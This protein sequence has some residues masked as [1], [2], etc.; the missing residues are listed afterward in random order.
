MIHRIDRVNPDVDDR[1][2]KPNEARLATNLRFGAS[3]DDE[4]LSGGTLFLGN[5]QLPFVAP[6]GTNVCVGIYAEYENRFVFFAM[7]NNNGNHGIYRINSFDNSVQA[8][9]AGSWL[10]FQQGDTYNV[11][12]TSIDGKLYWTDNVNEPRMVNVEKGIRTEAGQTVD[13]YPQA[14]VLDWFY[15]QIK[16]PPGMPLSVAPML[17]EDLP[18][19]SMTKQNRALTDTGFQYSYYYVY[20]N[21]EES[22]LAPYSKNT[23]GNYNIVVTIPADEFNTYATYTSLIK[24]IVIVIRNGNDGVWREIRYIPNDGVTRTFAFTNIL[25]SQK[26]IVSS[27]ITDARFD[28]VPLESATNEIAQNKINHGNYRLDYEPVEGITFNAE[29]VYTNDTNLWFKS[30]Y[31][32]KYKSFVPWG[33]YSIGVEFVDKFGRTQPVSNVSEVVAPWWVAYFKTGNDINAGSIDLSD[34]NSFTNVT[35][36]EIYNDITRSVAKFSISGDIP[37]WVDRV[38]IVR[39]KCKNIV[40]MKQSLGTMYMWYKNQDGQDEFFT[41]VNYGINPYIKNSPQN[42]WP[43]YEVYNGGNPDVKYTFQGYIIEFNAGEPIVQAENQYIYLPTRYSAPTI[44]PDAPQNNVIYQTWSRFKVHNVVGN[45]IYILASDGVTTHPYTA[46]WN[47][48]DTTIITPYTL[49]V[50]CFNTSEVNGFPMMGDINNYIQLVYNFVITQEVE[51]D[52]Q[53]LYTTQKSYSADE[54]RQAINNNNTLTGY[55]SGDAYTC[56]ALKTTR[57]FR[58][59]IKIFNPG[60]VGGQPIINNV[61]QRINSLGWYGFFISMNPIDIYKE[62]WNQDIGQVNTTNYKDTESRVLTNAIC[63][64][65]PLVQGSQVNGLNKFNSV[66]FRLA[67]AENGPITAL[68]TT[69]ATQREPGVMLAVGSYGISSFYYDAIQLTNVDGSSNVTTTDS[70]L[71]SQRPLLGQFGTSRPMS[72]TKTPLSTVYWWSDVVNDMI[73]YSNAGLERLGLTYSFSNFLRKEYNDNPLLITWYDQ[74]TDEILLSGEDVNTAVF[75]ERYKTFQGT[76]DYATPQGT[77]IDR[78]MGIATK[79][80]YI[81]DGQVWVTDLESNTVIK[82]F[83]FGEY[84]NPNLTIVTN[85]SPTAVKRWNQIKIFGNKPSLTVNTEL[86]TTGF[87]SPPTSDTLT[88]YIEPGWWIQRK[89]DWEAAIR[90]ASNTTGGVMAGK[91]MESRILYSNFAFNAEAFEKINFIEIRSNVSIVQ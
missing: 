44:A 20:D 15:S 91:L 39:S 11:S 49:P 54:Y 48:T 10:E 22:R 71:A 59:D 27:D 3:T 24:A 25:A 53:T 8:V 55:L 40:Q 84:K 58:N 80:Y 89:G 87:N 37:T 65:N 79:V 88:S 19:I 18:G 74:A 17:E 47:S 75:S 5:E 76:R 36:T 46:Q 69:N 51:A 29:I 64:S 61:T 62:Q 66:D 26:N 50:A 52:D 13:V 57:A 45:K 32:Y 63:F 28:S 7:Y 86:S 30:D 60:Q 82:N 38:N 81:V 31:E 33:R 23:Y 12:M 72:I 43:M 85:E 34:T 83:V 4:N 6:A 78:A 56:L 42:Q 70:Y 2:I 90:R 73:R 1:V 41:W 14:P 77:Y 21:F 16:R 35:P 67:P 9:V 68:V